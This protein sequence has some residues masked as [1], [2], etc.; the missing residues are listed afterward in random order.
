[1]AARRPGREF[2]GA[3]VGAPSPAAVQLVLGLME[4]LQRAA[5]YDVVRHL[6]KTLLPHAVYLNGDQL[7]TLGGIMAQACRIHFMASTAATFI[8]SF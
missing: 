6:V 2:P 4:D 8:H 5:L 3:A 7:R 1:V